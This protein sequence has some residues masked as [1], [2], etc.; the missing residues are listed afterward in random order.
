MKIIA[1]YAINDT[2]LVS[3]SVAETDALYD[4]G[5]SYSIG[6]IVRRDTNAALLAIA[7]NTS[8]AS[9]VL[10]MVERNGTIAISTPDDPIQVE[11][12]A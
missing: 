1:P 5:T 7:T 11:V 10:S 2:S 8:K 3:N 6:D 9:R 4:A 12:T